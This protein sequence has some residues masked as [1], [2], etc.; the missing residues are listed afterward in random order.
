MIYSFCVISQEIQPKCVGSVTLLI[1]NLYAYQQNQLSQE[2]DLSRCNGGHGDRILHGSD[3]VN[4]FF[5]FIV[6]ESLRQDRSFE[7]MCL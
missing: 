5:I 6:E 4:V 7:M 2:L 3:T 1:S